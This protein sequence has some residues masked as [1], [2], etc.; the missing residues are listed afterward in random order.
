MRAVRR[1]VELKNQS[2]IL[3][4]AGLNLETVNC[5]VIGGADKFIP[6]PTWCF[7]VGQIPLFRQVQLKVKK[8]S[9]LGFEAFPEVYRLTGGY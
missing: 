4:S 2:L 6:V 5:P 1:R 8:A 3:F 9:H 7:S